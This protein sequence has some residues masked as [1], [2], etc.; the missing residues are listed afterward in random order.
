V[1]KS[2][3]HKDDNSYSIFENKITNSKNLPNISLAK[4]L[5]SK[6]SPIDKWDMVQMHCGNHS[7]WE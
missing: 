6:S 4:L 5:P 1:I 3:F 7:L 2:L